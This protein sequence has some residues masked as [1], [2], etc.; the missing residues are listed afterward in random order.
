M[1]P[2]AAPVPVTAAAT[3][4]IT[5]LRADGAWSVPADGSGRPRR[6]AGGPVVQAAWSPDGTRL[7]LIRRGRL[8]VRGRVLMRVRGAAAGS[9]LAW[10]PQG[11]RIA[12][13]DARGIVSVPYGAHGSR[14]RLFG[15]GARDPAWTPNGRRMVFTL[16]GDLRISALGGG[17]GSRSLL[18]GVPGAP[19]GAVGADPSPDGGRV[20]FG[21]EGALY[22]FA[23][24]GPAVRRIAPAGLPDAADGSFS[25]TGGRIAFAI[26]GAGARDG[27]YVSRPDGTRPQRLVAAHGVRSP[28]WRRLSER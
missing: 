14:R 22:T 10:S 24:D 3:S 7:A 23:F 20:L 8:V 2:A 12:F 16:R 13:A 6:I 28:R 17:G 11:F 21:A 26:R 1:V 25:P 27:L 18:A 19:D 5:Y 4:S 9:R 15:A